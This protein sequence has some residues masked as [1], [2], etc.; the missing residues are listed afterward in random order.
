MNA[1]ILAIATRSTRLAW[2]EDEEGNGY[3]LEDDI[4]DLVEVRGTLDEVTRAVVAAVAP[5]GRLEWTAARAGH[6]TANIGGNEWVE[7]KV[8]LA[9]GDEDFPTIEEMDA[10]AEHVAAALAA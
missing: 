8:I 9:T 10:P 5:L 1:T 7:V 6:L 4:Q 3:H 2:L